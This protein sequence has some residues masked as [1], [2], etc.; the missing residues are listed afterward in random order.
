[1]KKSAHPYIYTLILALCTSCSVNKFIPENQYLLDEVKIVSDT[2]EVKPSLFNSYLRQNPN[3][4]WFNMVKIPMYIYGASGTDSTK[5]V[6]RFLTKIGHPPV[7]YNAHVAIKSK[8][9][10]QNAVRTRGILELK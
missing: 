5:R 2:K 9:H 4:K 6:N 10:I 7:I 1:M 8:P 3:A